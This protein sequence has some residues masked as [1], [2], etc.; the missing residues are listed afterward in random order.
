VPLGTRTGP[1]LPE[2]EEGNSANRDE[3]CKILGPKLGRVLP[4]AADATPGGRPLFLAYARA[5]SAGVDRKTTQPPPCSAQQSLTARLG[6]FFR[7]N[8]SLKRG[9]SLLRPGAQGFSLHF[10][11]Q[12]Q[13]KPRRGGRPRGFHLDCALAQ[14]AK[15]LF[16]RAG[17]Q[18][19]SATSWNWPQAGR[20]PRARGG[21]AKLRFAGA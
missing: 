10:A 19:R 18:Y 21:L 13:Q 3:L 5:T 14:R 20:A 6:K 12:T 1:P 8:S 15:S 2:A 9:I 7:F 17:D 16:R 11:T 4:M